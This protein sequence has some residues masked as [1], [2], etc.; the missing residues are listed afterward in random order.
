ML[1][2]GEEIA[3]YLVLDTSGGLV[4]LR[5]LGTGEEI[6]V[7]PM[8][9]ARLWIAPSGRFAKAQPRDLDRVDKEAREL[10]RKWADHLDEVTTG[11]RL[12]GEQGPVRPEYDPRLSLTER[13]A[14]KSEEMRILKVPCSPSTIRRKLHAYSAVGLPGL[15]DRRELRQYDP[16]GRAD[17][18]VM[19][20]LATVIARGTN[21]STGTVS[22][23]RF[24]VKKELLLQHPGEQVKVPPPTTLWRYLQKMKNGRDPSKKARTR[25][26]EA[27]VPERMFRPRPR[28]M[29]GQETQMDTTMLDFMVL[30]DKGEPERPLLTVIF[31]VPSEM[32]LASTMRL[33][34]TKGFDHAVTLARCLVPRPL[35]PGYGRLKAAA[36]TGFGET[37][38][39]SPLP[40]AESPI[41]A[42]PFIFPQRILTDNGP[43]YRSEVFRAGCEKYGISLTEAAPFTGS[44]KARAERVFGTIK[45]E[46][47]QYM[48]GY[49]G[50]SP[51]MKGSHPEREA[52]F[53]PV[54]RQ[55]DVRGLSRLRASQ[56]A[57]K[58]VSRPRPSQR[59]CVGRGGECRHV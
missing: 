24:R 25:R 12:F 22:R 33:R 19:Y 34:G 20:A 46:F 9:I 27:S 1:K 10:A 36:E 4:S 17:S 41:P 47:S 45:T 11:K 56:E 55:R 58:R 6:R 50:G 37:K 35:R 15:L 52:L 18:R 38:L 48:P 51:E 8:Y 49:T 30:N 53:R 21:E 2:V 26:S 44:D 43:D 23:L 3:E 39:K 14:H 16:F 32:V 54:H 29:M 28:F 31:D 40:S 5:H 57:S 7:D 42:R 13:I 59:S